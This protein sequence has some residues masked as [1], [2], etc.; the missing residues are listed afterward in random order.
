MQ[1]IKYIIT[2]IEGTT[3][4]ISFVYDVLFPYFRNNIEVVKGM[5][6]N[7]VVKHSII[8]TQ[9]IVQ[10]ETGRLIDIDGAIVQLKTWSAE[11]R[12]IGPLKSIQG[13]LWETGYKNGEIKGHV[14]ADV[15]PKLKEWK[16]KGIE[17]GIYSSGSVKAQQL[18][19]GHSVYGDLNPYFSFNFDLNIGHKREISSYQKIAENLHAHPET[20][21]FLSDIVEELDAAQ[22]A[23]FQ[24]IQL[25]REGTMAGKNHPVA[26]SFAGIDL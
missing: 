7:E 17:L 5:L 1:E 19:F 14:Y 21:L 9:K 20:I 26:R 18:L 25:V 2:D 10:Q 8:E 4:S 3:T 22:S 13:I 16:N 12:K 24:V 6:D 11:D 23:G 15:P